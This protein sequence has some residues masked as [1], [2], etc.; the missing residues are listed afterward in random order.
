VAT[1]GLQEWEVFIVDGGGTEGGEDRQRRTNRSTRG[2]WKSSELREKK[3]TKN[4]Q[5]CLQE[6]REYL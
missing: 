3:Q 2:I 5:F 6:M 1:P 4:G